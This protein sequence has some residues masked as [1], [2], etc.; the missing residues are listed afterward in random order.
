MKTLATEV[1]KTGATIARSI[2]GW[3]LLF[4]FVL[5][6]TM[7][8]GPA[9][10]L[11]LA[12]PGGAQGQAFD[13]SFTKWIAGFPNM[14][15]VVGGDVGA[16]TFTGEILNISSVGTIT[17]IEALYHMHGSRHSFTAHVYV[18]ENDAIGKAAITGLV[19]S[20]WLKG[21]S[22]EGEYTVYSTCPIATPGNS[23]GTL[24][25]QGE[26]ELHTGSS[27]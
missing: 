6:A 21:A 11:V 23:N 15:G 20:G 26:L 8:A 25:F 5:A 2:K 22:V 18:V 3:N 4:A 9:A 13:I 19:T 14:A 27:H 1:S 12:D 7:A 10:Q 24:C 16:G 17:K